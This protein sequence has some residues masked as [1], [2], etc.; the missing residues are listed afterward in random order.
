MF[1]GNKPGGLLVWQL[2]CLTRAHNM[3]GLLVKARYNGPPFE[4][5]ALRN[6]GVRLESGV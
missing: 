1:G 3:C 2:I 6:V 5:P 4:H